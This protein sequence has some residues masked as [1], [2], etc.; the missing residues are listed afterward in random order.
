MSQK[1]VVLKHLQKYK[2]IT[3]WQAIQ[4]YRIT[5]LSAV[6]KM[7]RDEGHDIDTERIVKKTNDGVVRYGKYTLN[8]R[9]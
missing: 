1:E 3:S 6:I 4:R 2:S 9:S 7:L 8:E 5:R